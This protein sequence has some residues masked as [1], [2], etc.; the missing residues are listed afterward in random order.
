M[1][2]ASPIIRILFGLILIVV[3]TIRYFSIRTQF[4]AGEGEEVEAL[5]FTLTADSWQ[6]GFAYGLAL[7][8][9]ALLLIL[10]GLALKKKLDEA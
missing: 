4:A 8:F 1:Q 3:A 7:L 5:G 6:F 9:G 10:G 2:Y